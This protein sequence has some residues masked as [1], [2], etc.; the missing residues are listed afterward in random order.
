MKATKILA[1]MSAAA[2]AASLL[3]MVSASADVTYTKTN[4]TSAV[5]TIT[6]NVAGTYSNQYI[7]WE[8]VDASIEAGTADYDLS[9]SG[10]KD[11]FTNLGYI[12]GDGMVAT[13]ESITINGYEFID[14]VITKEIN[15]ATPNANGI[16]NIWN[17]TGVKI[18]STDEKAYLDLTADGYYLYV[19]DEDESSSEED[20]SSEVV[21]AE[22]LLSCTVEESSGPAGNQWDINPLDYMSEDDCAKVATINATIKADAY[23]NGALGVNS[24]EADGWK[25]GDQC[26]TASGV[27]V[28][29]MTN[30]GGLKIEEGDDGVK[31]GYVQFQIWWMNANDDGTPATSE[32]YKVEFLDADGNVLCTIGEDPVVDDSSSEDDTSSEDATSSEDTTSSEGTTSSVVDPDPA[33]A[34]EED[35]EV[36]L[37]DYYR[38]NANN[39][40][41][42]AGDESKGEGGP[43]NG[44]MDE[45]AQYVGFKYTVNIDEDV[46]AELLTPVIDEE[47]GEYAKNEDGTVATAGWVNGG[48]GGNSDSTGWKQFTT[49]SIGLDENGDVSY[50]NIEKVSDGVY[51]IY[52]TLDDYTEEDGLSWFSASDTYA[53]LWMTD[54]SKNSIL[55]DPKV[56]GVTLL[57]PGSE[58]I[59]VEC[60]CGCEC[61]PDNCDNWDEVAQ[62]CGCGCCDEAEFTAFEMF[63]DANW[64]W[65]NWNSTDDLD[66]EGNPK[67]KGTDAIVTADE[68]S[69]EVSIS[70]EQVASWYDADGNAVDAGTEGATAA[71]I[72]GVN[73]W[74]VD[75]NGLADAVGAETYLTEVKDDGTVTTKPDSSLTSVDKMQKAKDAGIEISNV[76]LVA[77]GEEIAAIPEDKL[78]YGDI[79]GNGKIRIEIFNIY[80]D[81]SK[82]DSDY[83]VEDIAKLNETLAASESLAVTFDIT[84][85]PESKECTCKIHDDTPNPP[86][87]GP[88]DDSTTDSTDST[89]S[90]GSGASSSKGSSSASGSKS[91][92]NP[93][94]GAAA[95]GVV[96]VLLAGAAMVVSK[97]ND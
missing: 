89:D 18:Y 53:Q 94:T 39:Q 84:G 54:W 15:T 11:G 87:P 30:V 66:E 20:S 51:E 32:L 24:A 78:L 16:A 26:E 72:K 63:T 97:K 96:G 82:S 31:A 58:P 95:L 65:G 57:A 61:T 75:I 19:A 6:S 10:A 37:D 12:S 48:L 7:G 71:P 9:P 38:P 49:W 41:I 46:L 45:L 8:A 73:V 67:G 2:F 42:L 85:I 62:A 25:A 50:K 35:Y 4:V 88:G 81:T 80:G 29:S 40:V 34:P 44:K 93:S 70:A 36:S 13:V 55:G 92:S 27:G 5:Y 90:T 76:K 1:G 21:A 64:G 91:D 14:D 60:P 86:T 17:T 22:P 79:E 74:T 59:V 47:T 69:Y 52:Y 3:T 56:T 68:T 23:T 77:D 43:F 83:F 33:P 28:W